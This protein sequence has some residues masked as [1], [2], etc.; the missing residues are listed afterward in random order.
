LVFDQ[1]LREFNQELEF[2]LSTPPSP[3][4]TIMNIQKLRYLLDHFR[5]MPDKLYLK[6]NIELDEFIFLKPQK[7][8]FRHYI[9]IVV[10]E[11]LNKSCTNYS[12]FLPD[13]C[14]LTCSLCIS[15]PLSF[16]ITPLNF[17]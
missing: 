15:R 10:Q 8:I 2:K 6:K 4:N 16:N 17:L 9:Y 3:D 12:S 1:V 5:A 14:L 11:K 7:F 13:A